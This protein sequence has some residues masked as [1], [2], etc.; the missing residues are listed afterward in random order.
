MEA[1]GGAV[2]VNAELVEVVYTLAAGKGHDG[3]VV[4]VTLPLVHYVSVG[5]HV[6]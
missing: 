4:G 6:G 1:G 2:G 5:T 3:S